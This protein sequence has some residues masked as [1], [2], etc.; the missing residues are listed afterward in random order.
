M[1]QLTK[2][3]QIALEMFLERHSVRTDE[4]CQFLIEASVEMA[5]RFLKHLAETEPV[6]KEMK[7]NEAD[8]Y[9]ESL[10]KFKLE[11]PKQPEYPRPSVP[12]IYETKIVD[13]VMNPENADS[14]DSR[15][16]NAEEIAEWVYENTTLSDSENILLKGFI[17]ALVQYEVNK[18]KR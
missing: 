2:R 8:A 3:E 15:P 14:P 10:H 4:S 11:K 13:K 16:M 1:T 6:E 17:N 18:A 12:S 5:D 9:I 7:G